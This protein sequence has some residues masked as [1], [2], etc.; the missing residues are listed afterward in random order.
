VDEA[1]EIP[2]SHHSKQPELLDPSTLTDFP[3]YGREQR[4]DL[5]S[6]QHPIEPG[7]QRSLVVSFGALELNFIVSFY[8][9]T[10]LNA[11]SSIMLVCKEVKRLGKLTVW[12]LTGLA[13]ASY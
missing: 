3:A 7:Y 13:I 11:N 2:P 9:T 8:D 5:F 1:D 12:R 4:F 6:N 10:Y